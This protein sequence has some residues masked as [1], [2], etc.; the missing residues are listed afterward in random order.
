MKRATRFLGTV[1]KII[2]FFGLFFLILWFLHTYLHLF[3]TQ[4]AYINTMI[5]QMNSTMSSELISGITM[6][7]VILVLLIVIMPLFMKGINRKAYWK[8]LWRGVISAFVFFIS[9]RIFTYAEQKS[10][11][12]LIIAILITVAV[13]F[14]LIEVLS[15]AMRESEEVSFRTDMVSSI[16]AGLLFGVILKLI[17]IM[18][19]YLDEI[20]K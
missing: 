15:L 14:V 1:F 2:L 6:G 10:R 12:Y 13:T 9:N 7:S 11:F 19:S 4:L 17:T 20:A 16:A 5:A 8:S 3:D 18:Q